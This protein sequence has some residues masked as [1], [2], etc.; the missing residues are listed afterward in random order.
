MC[1]PEF[2]VKLRNAAGL[3]CYAVVHPH[4]L[5]T[6]FVE[7]V[8]GW[9]AERGWRTSLQGRKLYWVPDRLTKSSAVAEVATARGC[10]PRAR[11]R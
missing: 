7:D 8:S 6:G 10:R 5:P 11:R 2:T 9:A 1:R 4:R 3:F